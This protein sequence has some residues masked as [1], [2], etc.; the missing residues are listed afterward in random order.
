MCDMM[1]FELYQLYKEYVEM[2]CSLS[3]KVNEQN[4]TFHS[5]IAQ[6]VK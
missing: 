1:R 5:F 4:E 2:K 6:W 3:F